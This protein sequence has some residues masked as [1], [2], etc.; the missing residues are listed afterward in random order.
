IRVPG[1]DANPYLAVAA[2]LACGLEGVRRRLPLRLAPAAGDDGAAVPRRR[3][4][5]DLREAYEEMAAEGSFARTVLGDAFV[6]HFVGTR[7]HE[8]GLWS[9]AVTTWELSRYIEV[10]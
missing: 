3:L 10:V 8:W 6:E 7:R 2:I 5:R 1:A 9:R 4:A